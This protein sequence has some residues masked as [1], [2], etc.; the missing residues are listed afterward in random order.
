MILLAMIKVQREKVD[1]YIK[2]V[3]EKVKFAISILGLEV[4]P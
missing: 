3:I 4:M 2:A 1:E